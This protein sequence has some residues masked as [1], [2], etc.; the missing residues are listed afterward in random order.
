MF[1]RHITKQERRL[2]VRELLKVCN[3]SKMLLDVI[4]HSPRLLKVFD[5]QSDSYE[6][7]V[8]LDSLPPRTPEWAYS[9]V[10]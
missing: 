4:I 2:Y 9:P 10:E 1:L 8:D 5:N 3:Y 6:E 7:Y